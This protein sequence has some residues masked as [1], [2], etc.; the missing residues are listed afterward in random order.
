MQAPLEGK[1]L[2]SDKHSG[3]LQRLGL[4][5]ECQYA[6]DPQIDSVYCGDCKRTEKTATAKRFIFFEGEKKATKI[7]NQVSFEMEEVLRLRF[8]ILALA[9]FF[10]LPVNK[11]PKLSPTCFP[12]LF[13]GCFLLNTTN[14]KQVEM[15]CIQ[16]SAESCFVLF[17]TV[18]QASL[19]DLHLPFLHVRRATF[20]GVQL[21]QVQK[22]SDEKETKRVLA[23][24]S[25]RLSPSTQR[26]T[27]FK[28]AGNGS[29][30]PKMIICS[31]G[32]GI[33][34]TAVT[35]RNTSRTV[36]PITKNRVSSLCLFDACYLFSFASLCLNASERVSPSGMLLD[37]TNYHM[38]YPTGATFGQSFP[39]VLYMLLL[40]KTHKNHSIYYPRANLCS[41]VEIPTKVF[42]FPVW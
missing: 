9:R 2:R 26:K 21:M 22:R 41:C 11:V 39:V 23:L 38:K 25:Y 10:F 5:G 35:S 31:N 12:L 1:A 7:Y 16:S 15:F 34:L 40:L 27:T 30:V 20:D 36:K 3:F 32:S 28:R 17:R 24:K 13:E 42:H 29:S 37:N 4:L 18:K 8:E 33:D 14:S 19:Y 6:P